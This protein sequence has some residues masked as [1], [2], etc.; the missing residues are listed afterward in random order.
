MLSM[1]GEDD[2]IKEA[3]ARKQEALKAVQVE[4]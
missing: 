3:N 4:K 2:T 1:L